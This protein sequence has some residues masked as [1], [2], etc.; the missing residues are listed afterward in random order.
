VIQAREAFNQPGIVGVLVAE[1]DDVSLLT[2]DEVIP[3]R[4]HRPERLQRLAED[5]A[6]LEWEYTC[7]LIL[8]ARREGLRSV[9]TLSVAARD[10]E[11]GDCAA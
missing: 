8:P 4:S 7:A 1:G 6:H 10:R 3:L 11:L 9:P 5:F 2:D